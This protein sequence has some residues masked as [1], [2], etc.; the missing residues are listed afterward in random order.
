MTQKVYKYTL[1]SMVIDSIVLCDTE[2]EKVIN[3]ITGHKATKTFFYGRQFKLE[4]QTVIDGRTVSLQCI[5]LC[6]RF[7]TF[8][9]LFSLFC[10]TY[11]AVTAAVCVDPLNYVSPVHTARGVFEILTLVYC[12]ITLVAEI[13]QFKRYK[14]SRNL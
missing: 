2:R 4:R 6:F 7:Y 12:L 14:Y 8:N 3:S 11:A 10:A 5:I 9:Y 13:R 1:I